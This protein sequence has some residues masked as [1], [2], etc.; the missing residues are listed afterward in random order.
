MGLREVNLYHT[1]ATYDIANTKVM[2]D[3]AKHSRNDITGKLNSF[4][5]EITGVIINSRGCHTSTPRG[6][7]R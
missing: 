7:E 1:P 5:E 4:D 3:I 2:K 6:R